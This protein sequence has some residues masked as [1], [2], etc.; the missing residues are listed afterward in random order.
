LAESINHGRN[1]LAA[2]NRIRDVDSTEQR[3]AW[4]LTLSG[5]ETL[6]I[7]VGKS[8]AQSPGGKIDRKAATQP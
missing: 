3:L 5:L 4:Q 7:A 6:L 2:L 8:D 1:H